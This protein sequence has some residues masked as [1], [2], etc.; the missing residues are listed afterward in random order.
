MLVE[1]RIRALSLEVEPQA[2]EWRRHFHAHP[3]LANQEF[4]TARFVAERLR[5]FGCDE[6]MT[7]RAGGTGVIGLI[8]GARPGPVV[9]FRADMDALPIREETG[10]SYASQQTAEWG[11]RITY[12]MHACGHDAHT[13]ILLATGNVL[14]QMRDQ[15]EGAVLLVFQP[16]EEGPSTTWLGPSG[17]ER[18]LID[19]D[20]DQPKPEAMFALH[21]VP[22]VPAGQ[23]VVHS[24][25]GSYGMSV[26]KITLTG[27][28]GHAFQPW[29]CI[30][31]IGLAAQLVLAL[32]SI[33]NRYVDIYNNDVTV[34]LG[35]IQ[36][37]EKFNVIPS[38]VTIE[39]AI[40]LTDEASRGH[41]ESQVE[42]ISQGIAASG[43]ATAKV[44]WRLKIP[45]LYND[46]DLLAD[47]RGSLDKAADEVMPVKRLFL[48]DFSFISQRIPSL[49]FGLGAG[50]GKGDDRPSSALHRPDFWID[51]KA[52]VIGIRAFLHLCID[53]SSVRHRSN[54][55]DLAAGAV[56]VGGARAAAGPETRVETPI[57]LSRELP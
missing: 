38:E 3:E 43:G 57:S 37:G 39:G 50:P 28:G 51:E 33:P 12:V 29:A 44:E 52:L 54:G 22:E 49:F 2:I 13:A 31:P 46:P 7:G 6:V 19:G 55:H 45:I 10:L 25:N 14:A 11:G 35:S 21:V 9:G 42:Q 36:G 1:D 27:K 17:A 41:L 48:D 24:G 40:R 30:D 26:F 16:A 5:S 56:G 20:L 34:S 47:M 15:I 23:I 32:Q 4:E 18:L 8:K 53:Y